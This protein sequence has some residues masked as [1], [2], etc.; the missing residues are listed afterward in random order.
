[1]KLLHARSLAFLIDYL[2]M[3]VYISL[4]VGASFSIT[5]AFN[6]N[7]QNL[8]PFFAQLLGFVTLTLPIFFY[9]YS[10][11]IGQQQGSIGKQ[12][13]GIQLSTKNRKAVLLRNIYKFLPWEIAHTGVHWVIFYSLKG[14]NT[15][16]W[17]WAFL[18]TPQL[19]AVIYFISIIKSNGKSSL[20]DHYAK[21][22]LQRKT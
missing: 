21:T 4:L 12:K 18:I 17:V 3:L 14:I 7:P 15:P 1:M 16:F 11:E 6:L 13:M 22:S 8:H 20:Y 19:M 10:S 9:F 5:F 2:I